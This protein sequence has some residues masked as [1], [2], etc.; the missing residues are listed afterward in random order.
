MSYTSKR[1]WH[2]CQKIVLIIDSKRKK[3]ISAFTYTFS[4]VLL[5][6][7]LSSLDYSMKTKFRKLRHPVSKWHTTDEHQPQVCW[8]QRLCTNSMHLLRLGKERVRYSKNQ[9]RLKR[10]WD[11]Q[12]AKLSNSIK[13]FNSSYWLATY[14]V[15]PNVYSHFH[16]MCLQLFGTIP[17]VF[18]LHKFFF[19]QHLESEICHTVYFT[20]SKVA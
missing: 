2:N 12:N 18:I 10:L 9:S 19:Q 7:T 1:H 8:L 3:L 16:N 4:Y 11:V 6:N 20:Q 17:Y 13:E 15:L 5:S 14:K